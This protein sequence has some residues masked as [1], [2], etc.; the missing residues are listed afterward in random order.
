MTR[1]RCL[2]ALTLL[3]VLPGCV[4]QLA[5]RQAYLNQFV[6]HPE[7]MLVQQLGVPSRSFETQGVR[8][9][10]YT[11]HRTQVLPGGPPFGPWGWYGGMFP[12]DVIDLVCE[13]TFSV[14]KGVVTSYTLRG[15]ACG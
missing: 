1:L 10:A 4:N 5:Q 11:E 8:Y 14:A 9:L 12:P 2:L 7:S 15:N 6:G 13:T 3:C